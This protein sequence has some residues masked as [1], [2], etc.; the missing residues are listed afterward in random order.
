MKL[1]AEKRRLVVAS[2]WGWLASGFGAGFAPI[3]PG[4]AGSLVALLPYLALRQ[5]DTAWF[6]LALL[7][8]FALGVYAS[9]RVC[10]MLGVEDPGVI[11]VDE[12][13]GQWITLGLMEAGLRMVPEHI[14]VQPLWLVLLAGFI[15]FRV[16]D[17]LKPWPASLA[18][19]SLHGGF[20]AMLDDAIA[21]IWAAAVG[22]AA[23]AAFTLLL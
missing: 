15:A 18:D 17:I 11:V 5:L 10:R 19:R 3:A 9:E 1:S 20:G 16:C 21:G 4:T 6:W 8:A 14:G 13:L 2:P 23:L 7:L 22:L 12:W